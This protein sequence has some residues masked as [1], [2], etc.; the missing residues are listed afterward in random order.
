MK[1]ISLISQKGGTGKTTLALNLATEAV[2]NGHLVAIMDVDPQPSAVAWSDLRPNKHDPSVLDVKVSR[3]PVAVE[4]ARAQGLDLLIFDTGGRAEEGAHLAAKHSDLVIIPV[5]ASAVDMKSME[6]TRELLARAGAPQHLVILTRVKPF[7][8]RHE[9]ARAWLQEQGFN[10][11]PFVIGDRVTYQDSYAAGQTV[12]EYEPS[13][14]GAQEIQQL[15]K[16]A[17]KHVD[18]KTVKGMKDGTEASKSR[19]AR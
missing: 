19:R 3:I 10:V 15:Y 6:A 9:E 7:G 2:R 18:M 8:T 17:C 16:L 1:T 14:K 13:G 11:A 5:Q 12:S 4:T